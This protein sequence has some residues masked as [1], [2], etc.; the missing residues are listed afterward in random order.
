MNTSLHRTRKRRLFW[1]GLVLVLAGLLEL[2]AWLG[3]RALTAHGIFYQP[4]PDAKFAEYLARRHPVLGW[5]AG[6]GFTPR[7]APESERRADKPALVSLY[8]ESFTF[9]SEVSDDEAWGN[10]LAAKLN[11]RVD[12]FGV[13][14]YG[15]DQAF[16]RFQLNTNDAARVIVLGIV[17]ENLMRNVNQYRDLIYASGGLGFK[18]RFVLNVTNGLEL[19]PL[20]TLS[21]ADFPAF[22]RDPGRFLAH[23]FFTPEGGR[24]VGAVGFPFLF[25]LARSTRHFSVGPRLRGEPWYADFLQAGHSSR[26]LPL[27]VALVREF[28]RVCRERGRTPLILLLPTGRD[29][30]HFR[31]H[32]RWVHASLAEALAQDGHVLDV[33]VGFGRSVAPERFESLYVAP[34]RHMNAVGNALLADLVAE[35]IKQLT[36]GK[37]APQAV[38]K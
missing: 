17:T 12:N 36:A 4:Q 30:Q 31:Q 6:E 3:C 22:A 28:E 38:G 11:A 37:P 7:R 14:G 19:V 25:S 15:T 29:L 2:I 10:R 23:E 33:A 35:R 32:G 20:P 8:G 1:L 5:P 18:P 21:A 34:S 9:G 26:A 16:L 24:G 27:T 13:G